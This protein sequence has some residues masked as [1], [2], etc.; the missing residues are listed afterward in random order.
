M[1]TVGSH[2]GDASDVGERVAPTTPDDTTPCVDDLLMY[3]LFC[4]KRYIDIVLDYLEIDQPDRKQAEYSNQSKADDG[5]SR[6]LIPVHFLKGRLETTRRSSPFGSSLLR[7]TTWS[8]VI[9]T[10]PKEFCASLFFSAAKEVRLSICSCM[11][12][13]SFR[14]S[15][16]CRSSS[17]CL[18]PESFSWFFR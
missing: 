12:S 5:S 10:R 15:A 11:L 8:V 14:T 3:M 6:L 2:V 16:N 7:R 1:R 9:G 17:I 4:A 18:S 13:F